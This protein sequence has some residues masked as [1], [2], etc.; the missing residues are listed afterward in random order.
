[1]IELSPPRKEDVSEILTLNEEI[2]ARGEIT[3]SYLARV[4]AVITKT[5]NTRAADG[6]LHQDSTPTFALLVMNVLRNK[7]MKI[8]RALAHEVYVKSGANVS[9]TSVQLL[10]AEY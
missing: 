5:E 9:E 10:L 1:M 3:G 6:S 8:L 4:G 2:V 7:I